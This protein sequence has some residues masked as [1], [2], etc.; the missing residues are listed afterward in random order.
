VAVVAIACGR[1]LTTALIVG[2]VGA[3][4]ATRTILGSRFTA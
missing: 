4:A 2:I 3:A 1:R